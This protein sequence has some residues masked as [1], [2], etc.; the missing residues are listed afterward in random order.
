MKREGQDRYGPAELKYRISRKAGREK[1]TGLIIWS[2]LPV[3]PRFG[4]FS[5]KH[6]LRET[7]FGVAEAGG[8]LERTRDFKKRRN[9]SAGS[10]LSGQSWGLIF[11]K[12][13]TRV[14]SD[15]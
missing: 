11:S 12:S 9:H 10:A 14:L 15:S 13:S 2:R 5:M 8:I 3:E 4:V 7:D 6:F 1:L